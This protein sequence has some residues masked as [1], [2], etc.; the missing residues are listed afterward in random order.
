MTSQIDYFEDYFDDKKLFK[1]LYNV[2]NQA[3]RILTDGIF[4]HYT[5]HSINHSNRVLENCKLLLCENL[6]KSI[7]PV[8][9]LIN[10]LGYFIRNMRGD[11]RSA[12]R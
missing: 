11:K 12:Y 5:D 10:S 8:R 9:K 2:F 7:E 1:S 3:E 4:H 6:L